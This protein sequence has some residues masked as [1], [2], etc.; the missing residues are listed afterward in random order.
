MSSIAGYDNEVTPVS[1]HDAPTSTGQHTPD[2]VSVIARRLDNLID[3][4]AIRGEVEGAPPDYD[5]R[6]DSSGVVPRS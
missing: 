5:A 1:T 3:A 4:L 2:V 6:T